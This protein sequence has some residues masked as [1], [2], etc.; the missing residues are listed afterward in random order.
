MKVG[1]LVLINP[2]PGEQILA[3]K[4]DPL[5]YPEYNNI[6][7]K[8]DIALLTVRQSEKSEKNNTFE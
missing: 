1:A 5:K 6:T 4:N 8:H 7:K 3:L 2:N